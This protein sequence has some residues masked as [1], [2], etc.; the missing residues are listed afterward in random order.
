MMSMK[1]ALA[2]TV[3]FGLMSDRVQAADN[4]RF[5]G[6]LR[7]HA[8][9]LHPSDR[10]IQINFNQVGDQDLYLNGGTPDEVFH[11]RLQSCNVAVANTV[12]VTF[13]G[14]ENG[15]LPGTLALDAGS[16]ASGFAIALKDAFRQP[17]R[18]GDISRS[19]LTGTD[20]TL[21]FYRRLQV[22]PDALTHRN[23]QPGTFHA[24]GT[25]TLFY[26]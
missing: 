9:T 18:L 1:S 23:I 14:N 10:D 20:T 3:L 15:P 21:V 2:L 13:M 22:E 7:A 17:L 24:S 8:C 11:I 4:M 5:S 12:E 19:P 25:F 26:P 16:T 6:A